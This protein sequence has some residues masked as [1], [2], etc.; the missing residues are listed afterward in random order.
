[1][2]KNYTCFFLIIIFTFSFSELKS[3][4]FKY[5]DNW[6]NHGISIE[7]STNNSIKLNFSLTEFS[8][9]DVEIA[10]QNLKVV[11]MPEVFLPNNSGSPD[12]PGLS[13]YIALP[14]GSVVSLKIIDYR[15]EIFKN[16]EIAPAPIIP[17]DT[18][19]GPLQYSKNLE[20]YS[21]DEF[22]PSKYV[23]VSEQT[24]IRGVD[25]AI[26]GITPFQYNPVSKELIVY[27]DIKIEIDFEG[28]IGKFGDDKYRSRWFDPIL[29]D[30]FLNQEL[31]PVVDYS[32]N[33]NEQTTGYEYLIIIPDN[34]IYYSW[35]DSVKNFRQEQGIKTGIV[36]L[37]QIGGNTTTA[38][39][40]YI[41]NAYNNWDI[42]PAAILF[43]ADYGTGGATGNGIINPVHSYSYS[44]VSDN[45]YADMTGNHLPDIAT[46]RMTAQ[47]EAQLNIMVKKF[48]DYERNPPVNPTYYDKPVTAMGWQTE[49]WF[50]LCSEV[51]NGF[52][53][54]TLGKNP[55]RENAIYSGTPGTSS[56]WSTATNTATVVSYFGPSG[57]NYIPQTPQHLTDW[58]GNATRLN[59]DINNG[60]FMISHRDHG[61]WNRWGEPAYAI[62]N[63]TG[64]NNEDLTFILSINCLTG[65]YNYSSEV[66]TEALHRQPKRAL[67]LIAASETSYSFVNDCFVWG[68]FDYMWPQFMPAYGQPGV[69]KILPAFGNVAGKYFLDQSSWPYNTTNKVT[70]YYLFHHHGDAFSSVYS[71][72]PQQLAITHDPIILSG[73][74][75]FTVTANAGAMIALTKDGEILA[76]ASATGSPVNMQI[77][78][79]TPGENVRLTITKQNYY[80]YTK[81]IQVI[82]PTGAYVV[83]QSCI[84]NDSTAGNMG[85]GILDYHESPFLCLTVKNLGSQQASNVVVKL[86]ST[87]PYISIT[88]SVEVYGS[89]APETSKMIWNGFAVTVADNVPDNHNI[90]FTVAA[91]DGVNEWI[92]NFSLK[93]NAPLLQYVSYSISDSSGNNNGKIDPGETVVITV[94]ATNVGNS[95]AF[96]VSGL[97]VPSNSFLT[98]TSSAQNYG[99]IDTAQIVSGRFTAVASTNTPAG[100]SVTLNFA[101]TGNYGLTGEG[102]FNVIIGQIPVLIVCV[103][104]NHNSSPVMAQ[105]IQNNGIATQTVTAFPQDLQIYSSIFVCLGTYSQNHKLSTDEGNLLQGYLNGGGKLYIEGGDTWKYDPQTAVHPMFKILPIADGSGNLNTLIGQ[106]GSMAEGMTFTFNGENSYIDQI[107]AIAPAVLMFKNNSPVYGTMVSYDNGYNSYR[108]V[109]SSFEFGGLVN[110]TGISTRDN[111]MAKI[112]EFFGFV[113]PVELV[114]FKAEVVQN[115]IQLNWQTA[116]ETNNMGFDI[117]RSMDGT[118]YEVIGFIK[119]KGTCTENTDYSYIDQSLPSFGTVYYRL[120]QF[121]F[122]GTTEYS[123]VIEVEYAA[124]PTE[125]ELSQNYPNPFNPSTTIRFALPQQVRV[126]LIVYD[127]LGSEVETIINREVEAGYHKLEW[128]ASKY[129]SGMYIYRLT[130]GD[131]TSVKKMMILK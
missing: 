102:S 118:N 82:P 32:N 81:D 24:T 48:L 72:M 96:G 13:K 65:K 86:R 43:M 19:D 108:T 56:V 114:S 117:E 98:V 14:Q 124:L 119:G 60:T 112:L 11:H 20:I 25:A 120:K 116:T 67:G 70:T 130:A 8:L 3:Q 45:F 7:R 111:L 103:D 52:W 53:K 115:S 15:T 63:M 1:M 17:L 42:P 91:T 35:A 38:I 44:A 129:S 77:P 59:N 93:A 23:Q 90:A 78:V 85:N 10:G 126:S 18:E 29:R 104:K 40:T 34:P 62:S 99:T 97:L 30:I 69:E 61:D 128:N 21:L 2:V 107:D 123:H 33:V 37:T 27:K 36:N 100:Q 16:I 84:V 109:G 66:F 106:T 64:L 110:G 46:A 89:I 87:S 122:D 121:D 94:R 125:F 95:K 80:R 5:Q 12:L 131:F 79:I 39:K 92:S 73:L 22:Y 50:Q 41:T 55:V 31:I 49:R 4:Q 68:L 105:A 76:V 74:N 101:M 113:V 83:Q 75:T 71:E 28:G 54:N 9:D 6:G 88:D 57:L 51:V 58:G 26:L 127:A 47:T